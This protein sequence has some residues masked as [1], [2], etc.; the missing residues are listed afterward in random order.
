VGRSIDC[1]RLLRYQDIL[2]GGEL[3][4]HLNYASL[5]G[6]L[7]RNMQVLI[8]NPTEMLLSLQ[9]STIYRL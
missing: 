8:M 6:Q 1:A 3:A 4:Y 5:V 2:D 9:N 7:E